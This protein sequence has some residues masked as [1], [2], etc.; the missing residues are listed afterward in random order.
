MNREKLKIIRAA[1]VPQSLDTFCRGVLSKLNEKYEVVALSSPGEE[2][3]A[4][5]ER[6]H[7]RTITVPMERH[8]SLMKDIVA[9]LRLIQVFRRERPAMVHSMTPKA[10]LL[11]MV[12]AKL[13]NVPVRVHSFTGL[14]FPTSKGLQRRILMFTD[15]MT[16]RCATHIIPEGEGVKRDL[17]DNGITQ[18]P[19]R[20]LGFGNV[21][22]VD[23][24]FY[25]RRPEV[26][27]K[28]AEL[29]SRLMSPLSF[30]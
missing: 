30:L 23:M 28:A 20:V 9:L 29:K 12:A 18:K 21:R 24:H 19:L 26:M 17:I 5:A 22:G 2:M 16:C 10:G 7:V 15:S 1:T 3:D 6:E 14:V 11:C 8:I 13:T 27:K 25:S 4:I